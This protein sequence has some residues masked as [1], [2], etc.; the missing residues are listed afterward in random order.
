MIW[1]EVRADVPAEHAAAYEAYLRKEHIPD[2]METGCF[3]EAA[4]CQ[5]ELGGEPAGVAESSR[6]SP[7]SR[8]RFRSAYLA[9]DREALDRYFAEHAAR[10]RDHA[11]RRFPEGLRFAR[12]EWWELERWGRG[13]G[14]GGNEEEV[15]T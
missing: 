6:P 10:L 3:V 15:V 14:R 1:Y 11:L 9:P 2:L 7:G 8:V 13:R 4:F 5:A 12:E